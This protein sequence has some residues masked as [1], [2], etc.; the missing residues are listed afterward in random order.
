MTK[1]GPL[2]S[3]STVIFQAVQRGFG[4]QDIAGRIG[5]RALDELLVAQAD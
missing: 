3:T 4:Q 1:G 5:R 2:D